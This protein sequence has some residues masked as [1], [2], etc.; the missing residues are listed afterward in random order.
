[1]RPRRLEITAFGPYAEAVTLDFDVLAEEGLFLIH[2]PT[3]GGKTS[4]LDAMTYALYG[5]PAGDRGIDRLRSDHADPETESRVAFEFC[6]RGQDYRVSRVPQHERAKRTGRGTT[7]Q[8][9]KATL[10]RRQ[11]A[12]WIPLAEGVEEVGRAVLDLIG[13]NRQQF[14]QVVVLPQ[15]QFA[16]ALRADP[17][18]RRQLLSTLFR[19]ERFDRYTQQL[20]ERARQAEA[21]EAARRADLDGL[22]RQAIVRWADIAGESE[23]EAVPATGD[24]DDA[25]HLPCGMQPRFDRLALAATELVEEAGTRARTAE[26]S[27]RDAD[28]QLT[29]ATLRADRCRR[30]SQALTTLRRLDADA[31]QV[32]IERRQL[33]TAELAA[34]CA[35]LLEAVAAA[36]ADLVD[37][38]GRCDVAVARLRSAAAGLPAWL[39]HLCRP[40]AELTDPEGIS[41]DSAGRA[42]DA[43]RDAASHIVALMRRH[44]ALEQARTAAVTAARD[45]DDLQARSEVLDDAAGRLEAALAV[46]ASDDNAARRA[47]DRITATAAQVQQL[48]A[49]A[50]AAGELVGLRRRHATALE[51]LSDAQA[52]ATDANEQHLELLQR[53][54][55]GMAGELAAALVDGVACTVCGS[56]THPAPA[57]DGITGVDDYQISVAAAAAARS[58]QGANRLA[59][60]VAVNDRALAATTAAAGAAGDDPA[61]AQRQAATAAADLEADHDLASR[62]AGLSDRIEDLQRQLH[63]ARG[64]A[65]AA[66]TDT[67]AARGR[68]HAAETAVAQQ[69]EAL[70]RDLPGACD[71][72]GAAEQVEQLL[73]AV[74]V[75]TALAAKRGAAKAQAASCARRLAEL[76]VERGF[77]DAKRARAALL[78]DAAVDR[79]RGRI[80]AYDEDRRAARQQLVDLGPAEDPPDLA[81]LRTVCQ[82]LDHAVGAAHRRH[83]VLSGAAEELSRL[84]AQY[85]DESRR[86]G[87][88]LEESDRLRHLADVCSG[89]GNP[90]RMSLER[91]VLASYLEE[92]T[93]AASVRLLAMTGGRYALRH[94]DARV[95][96]GGASGLGIIVSDAYT[97]TERD[98][99]TLSGGETFQ[100]SLALALG[101]ADVVGRHAGGVH[102]DTLFVDE[103]FGALDAEALEQALAEL[104]RLREGGRLVGIISH[105]GTLRERITAGIEVVRTANGSNARVTAL[106][107]P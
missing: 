103:G 8:K 18:D 102:L 32:A 77:D 86:L 9:P 48:R 73:S 21:A 93:E 57:R 55:D 42:R 38:D 14:A 58:R 44:D 67:A 11:E 62:A 92:I 101:V 87:P 16:D 1:M 31:N 23:V 76:L 105:V 10:A 22:W 84:A 78:A 60:I 51:E 99:S 17:S 74:E 34:P 95:K 5:R 25:S 50:A 64:G 69:A 30:R 28:A 53:R 29:E 36:D 46:A 72:R 96:G 79:L 63:Q 3:G 89:T 106:A 91:Y 71:P 37:L 20:L 6:L 94:S 35:P 41:V 80:T 82:E 7:Q 24:T 104:D 49:A 47:I 85:A 13:L 27:A 15:G 2:G 98:P 19:T 83:G 40:L 59:E 43:V 45:A 61:A 88:A 68:Q 54:I 97:G 100:A 107:A 26:A 81:R 4:L 70:H 39:D 65:S 75:V 52:E 90:L 12:T 56:T 33:S 66:R